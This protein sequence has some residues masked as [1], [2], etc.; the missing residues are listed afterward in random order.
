M[1]STVAITGASG[2]LGQ[3][4]IAGAPSGVEIV[5][6]G[7]HPGD[8]PFDM[9][10]PARID[11]GDADA[12]I[13]A[14]WILTPRTPATARANV[15]ASMALLDAAIAARARFVF[16][17]TMSASAAARSTYGSAKRAVEQATL[18]Y[19]NGVVVR[20]GIIRDEHGRTGMLDATLA[21]VANL[22]VAVRI[23]P[24]PPA[25]LV[26]LHRVVDAIWAQTLN[27]APADEIVELVDEW[28]TLN[29]LVDRQRGDREQPGVRVPGGAMNAL[30]SVARH[31]PVGLARDA[32]DSW[33]GLTDAG[34]NRH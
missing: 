20:P 28:S 32:A 15:A 7:R 34:A 23:E 26:A 21:Q 2:F 22:P 14:A 18:A 8:L 10:H 6:L 31:A 16:V 29:A 1:P 30:M 25:P 3:A 9:R 11:L 5:T 24:D 17:S 4:L 19:S 12:V 27:P 33:L 13:H